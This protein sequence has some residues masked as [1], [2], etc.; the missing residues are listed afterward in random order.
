MQG[1][2]ITNVTGYA[3]CLMINTDQANVRGN[4]EYKQNNLQLEA[5]FQTHARGNTWNLCR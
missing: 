5:E 4:Q 2:L 1:T 3:Q